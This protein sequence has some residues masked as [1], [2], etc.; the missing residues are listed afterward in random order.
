MICPVKASSGMNGIF[1]HALAAHLLCAGIA[2][3]EDGLVAA[4]ADVAFGG[5]D[6]DAAQGCVWE[7][8][9]GGCGEGWV[10]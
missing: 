7:A 8:S 6:V 4:V 1:C 9:I 2:A 5:V 3:L 10:E